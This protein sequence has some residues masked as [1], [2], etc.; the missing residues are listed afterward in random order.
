MYVL[1]V[2]AIQKYKTAVQSYH[3]CTMMVITT[4]TMLKDGKAIYRKLPKC[5][6]TLPTLDDR[7]NA[8]KRELMG[9]TPA[10]HQDSR[11]TSQTLYRRFPTM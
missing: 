3:E 7:F 11:T 1:Q 6:A 5:T 8:R 2:D 9:G 10:G 4:A